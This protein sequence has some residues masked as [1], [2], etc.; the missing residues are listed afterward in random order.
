MVDGKL[1]SENDAGVRAL[2]DA[3]F[4]STLVYCTEKGRPHPGF[5]ILESPLFA[6]PPEQ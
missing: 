6:C 4:T 2:L 1:R 5:V 3:A